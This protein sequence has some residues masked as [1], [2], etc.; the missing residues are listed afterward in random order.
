MAKRTP[1][2]SEH[3]SDTKSKE[4]P[5]N[6]G[7]SDRSTW[8]PRD[9]KA[10]RALIIATARDLIIEVGVRQLTHRLVAER[11]NI[12]LG[13]TTYYFASLEDLLAEA[14]E[15]Q[16][17][18]QDATMQYWDDRLMSSTDLAAEMADL[19]AT[20]LEDGGM[21][22]AEFELFVAA[23]RSERIRGIAKESLGR[24]VGVLTPLIGAESATE[25]ASFSEGIILRSLI[26]D[27]IPSRHDLRR[28]FAK[29]LRT[30]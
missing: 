2:S 13:S 30:D 1:G 16:M 29:I 15:Y 22:T 23:F 6:P 18:Q 14:M 26:T 17:Q 9:P 21:P 8:R 12:P 20:Y 24:I 19:V 27:V 7:S 4:K 10:R 11:A 25:L 3:D 28:S 5:A